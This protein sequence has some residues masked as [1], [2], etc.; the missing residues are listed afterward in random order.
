MSSSHVFLAEW[1][2][3][4]LGKWFDTLSE[5]R[6]FARRKSRSEDVIVYVHHCHW[7]TLE[8]VICEGYANGRRDSVE[9]DAA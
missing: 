7:K 4:A 5:A 9:R 1:D 3:R 2:E 6:A 8:T